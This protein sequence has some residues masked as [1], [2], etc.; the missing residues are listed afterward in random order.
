MLRKM[1]WRFMMLR[2]MR[3]RGRKM[4][5]LRM[6]MLRRRTDPKTATYTLCEPAPSKCTWTF[7]NTEIYRKKCPS[8]EPRTTLCVSLR[9]RNAPGH[10]T[11]ATLCENLQAKCRGPAEAPS[12]STGLYTYHKSPRV[13]THCLGVWGTM[14]P[15]IHQH[16]EAK[17]H[18]SNVAKLAA[19]NKPSH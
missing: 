19:S 10:F 7:H 14:N 13:W 15:W 4:M 5:M 12:S 3:S 18:K 16:Q 17:N 6:M 9:R 8:P 1:R 2:M 11:R